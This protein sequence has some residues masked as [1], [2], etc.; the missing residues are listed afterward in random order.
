[1]HVDEVDTSVDVAD[2]LA[3]LDLM[4]YMKSSIQL[5]GRHRLSKRQVIRRYF[6]YITFES[7]SKL[8]GEAIL[9]RNVGVSKFNIL[10]SGISLCY[11]YILISR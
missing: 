6:S 3:F 2:S 10:I 11:Y 9:V 7:D 5:K 1:V 8:V 4:S